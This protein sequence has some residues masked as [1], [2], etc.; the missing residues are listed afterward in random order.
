MAITFNIAQDQWVLVHAG[1]AEIAAFGSFVPPIEGV[2]RNIKV[3]IFKNGCIGQFRLRLHTSHDYNTN[4]A[5]S[6]W[7]N[8]EDIPYPKFVGNVRF[9][10]SR[11]V[12]SKGKTYFV[13]IESMNY[14]RDGEVS[15]MSY[16]FDSP[17]TTNQSVGGLP[18]DYP[19]RMEIF[20]K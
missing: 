4:Y 17:M 11:C 5:V 9:D 19:I 3:G 12:L 18:S 1:G 14:T 6:N 8:I 7:V 10:F 20:Y 2:L 13:T 16:L 15:Y